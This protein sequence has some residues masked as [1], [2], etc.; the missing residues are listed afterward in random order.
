MFQFT[1]EIGENKR[2]IDNEENSLKVRT[3]IMKF[4]YI[5]SDMRKKNTKTR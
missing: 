4:I 3:L 2:F 1:L 5:G